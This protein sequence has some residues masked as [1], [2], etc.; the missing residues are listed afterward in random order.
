MELHYIFISAFEDRY[1]QAGKYLTYLRA[2]WQFLEYVLKL[3]VC[4]YFS[5]KSQKHSRILESL[6]MLNVIVLTLSHA[7]TGPKKSM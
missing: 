3:H 6:K 7:V 5:T 4:A 2:T 1:F